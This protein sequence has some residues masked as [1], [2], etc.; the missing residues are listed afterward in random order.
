MIRRILVSVA[1]LILTVIGLGAVG[2]SPLAAVDI[3]AADIA[4]APSRAILP[5]LVGALAFAGAAFLVAFSRTA[6]VV[7][8]IGLLAL[9]AV[10]VL[11][12]LAPV[13]GGPAW[14]G[15][16][17]SW[18]AI[19]LTLQTTVFA[20]G[21]AAVAGAA[22]VTVSSLGARARPTRAARIVSTIAGV[23]ALGASGT[24]LVAGARFGERDADGAPIDLRSLYIATIALLFLIMLLMVSR[25]SVIVLVV[26]GVGLLGG[27]V[28]LW[29]APDLLSTAPLITAAHVL[30]A[31]GPV[32]AGSILL[33]LAAGVRLRRRR[34]PLPPG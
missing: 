15:A 4:A 24:V 6:T 11:A 25:S 20:S 12:A 10:A 23:L 21:T 33:G 8:G 19:A 34:H 2:V 1:A 14:A 22:L 13:P 29:A 5:T 3:S 28:T 31:G 30:R 16:V 7:V 17:F 26:A 27:G 18:H 32:V 9:T